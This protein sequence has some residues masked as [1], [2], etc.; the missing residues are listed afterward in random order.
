MQTSAQLRHTSTSGTQYKWLQTDTQRQTVTVCKVNWNLLCTLVSGQH[1]VQQEDVKTYTHKPQSHVSTATFYCIQIHS[2]NWLLRI[3]IPWSV[4]TAE[5][6]GLDYTD[7]DSKL[8]KQAPIQYQS[9]HKLPRSRSEDIIGLFSESL[10]ALLT[11]AVTV[12]ML[13][14][15]WLG[16]AG[17]S[18]A[19]TH[20]TFK[21]SLT[22]CPV[23]CHFV[24]W[25]LLMT[26]TEDVSDICKELKLERKT[27]K[28]REW[29]T[30]YNS[31]TD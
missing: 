1:S 25:L 28:I 13:Q 24:S 9:P 7:N 11:W 31:Y 17:S 6:V 21:Q 27:L 29:L 23:N 10:P 8:A 12:Y 19:P 2:L 20:T 5:L 14:C 4:L 18:P 15:C 3:N 16:T 30:N 22:R 26:N